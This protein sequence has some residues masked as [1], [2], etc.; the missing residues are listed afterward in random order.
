MPMC[1]AVALSNLLFPLWS[2]QKKNGK[3]RFKGCSCSCAMSH[4]KLVKCLDIMSSTLL[5][6]LGYAVT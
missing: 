6:I 2:C 5:D 4:L 1:S 3:V